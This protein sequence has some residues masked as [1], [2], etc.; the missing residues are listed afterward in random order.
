MK[1]VVFIPHIEA[2]DGRSSSYKFSI[3]SWKHWCDKNNCDLVVFDT[4]I[5]PV[6]DMKVTWQRYY[7]MDILENS[8]IE[9][10]QVCM[11]DAD[12]IVHPDCPNFF[13]M[14][15]GK[16]C[17][18]HNDGCYD[19]V[20]RS[21]ENYHEHLFTDEP[22][23]FNYWEY[24]NTGFLIFNKTHKE[25]LSNFLQFYFDNRDDITN[26]QETYHVGTCQPV[27]NYYLR[28][29]NIDTKLLPYEFNMQDLPR[30]EIL[31]HEMTFT[32]LGWVYHFNAIAQEFQDKYGNVDYW[33]EKTYK[34]FYND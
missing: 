9:Y 28:R 21:M 2:G 32:K 26:I 34:H 27:M 4:P 29:N 3:K 13:E 17:G 10:D 12:T 20:C 33:M 8:D 18:V 19:W 30:K 1:N 22:M 23:P 14:S 31:D 25:F 6:K 24:I 15:E 16:F 11:I 7:A 5:C